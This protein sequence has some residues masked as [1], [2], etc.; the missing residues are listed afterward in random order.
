MYKDLKEFAGNEE[1][2]KVEVHEYKARR[3]E[4]EGIVEELREKNHHSEVKIR[5]QQVELEKLRR[6]STLK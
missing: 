2:L 6:D 4:L 5:T 3:L 1:A